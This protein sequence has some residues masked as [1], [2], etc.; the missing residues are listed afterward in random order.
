MLSKVFG[1]VY[2][3]F[4]G[5]KFDQLLARTLEMDVVLHDHMDELHKR[6]DRLE[7][8]VD[9]LLERS[10]QTAALRSDEVAMARRLASLE[11]RVRAVG[12][13]D[14]SPRS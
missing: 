2:R 1:A 6:L 4:F 10:R 9:E 12:E 14:S 5:S 11:D 3:R 7:A 8:S 13:S